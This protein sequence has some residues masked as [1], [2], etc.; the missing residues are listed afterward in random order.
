MIKKEKNPKKMDNSVETK[1][2]VKFY[3]VLK[4]EVCPVIKAFC[5]SSKGRQS[6]FVQCSLSK[7]GTMFYW[8]KDFQTVKATSVFRAPM[9]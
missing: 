8:P 7:Q 1:T 3:D 5:W 2:L 6:F 9:H 4:S